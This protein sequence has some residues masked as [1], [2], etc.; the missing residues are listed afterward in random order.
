MRRRIAQCFGD[1]RGRSSEFVFV[2]ILLAG[3]VVAGVLM[4]VESVTGEPPHPIAMFGVFAVV[5]LSVGVGMALIQAGRDDA[6]E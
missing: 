6:V 3:M 1:E 2:P 4:A 5:F